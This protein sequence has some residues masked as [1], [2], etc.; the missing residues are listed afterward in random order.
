VSPDEN[1]TLTNEN[2]IA[3]VRELKSKT[4]RDIWLCG[5]DLASTLFPQIDE[6]VLK[7]N[8]IFKRSG[9]LPING[10]L[11]KAAL[12]MKDKEI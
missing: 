2:P 1:V 7:V 5:G 12:E 11:R 3:F 4:G 6:I 10:A 8:P 9:I